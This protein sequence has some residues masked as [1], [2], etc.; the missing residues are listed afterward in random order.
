MKK[1]RN[2]RIAIQKSGRL[3]KRCLALLSKCGIEFE[4]GQNQLLCRAENYPIELML[5][6]DDDIPSY[7]RDGVCEVGIVGLNELRE[8]VLDRDEDNNGV[9]I[10]H[11]LGFSRCRL[12]LAV[13]SKLTY[14]GL[15]SFE[16]M[17][18]ATSYPV[19]LKRFMEKNGIKV[20]IFEVS[21]SVEV[22]PAIGVADGVCDLVSTGATLES[23][24]LRE[25]ETILESEAVLVK[26]GKELSGEKEA[27]LAKLLPRIEAVLK[28][29]GSR[30]VM[31][32]APKSVLDKVFAILPGMETPTI[33]ELGNDSSRVAVHAVAPRGVF[34]ETIEQL[35]EVGASSILVMPIEK[36]IE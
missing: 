10:L 25:V 23:N 31:M 13:P 32:N 26:T 34:W 3:S 19:I 14:Q 9:T 15:K 20:N 27:I 7:V 2:L 12:A 4:I 18:I 1:S 21:G 28:A 8:K 5:V 22:T 11:H 24:G 35:K 29:E 36:I 17:N 6:R 16:G 30:Y 33:M